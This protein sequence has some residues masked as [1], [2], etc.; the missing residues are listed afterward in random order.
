MSAIKSERRHAA[1]LQLHAPTLVEV[2]GQRD[3]SMHPNLAAVYE[4]VSPNSDAYGKK[5][6]GVLRDLSTN[7]AFLS[8]EAL[9]LMSRLAFTFKLE[10]FGQIEVLGWV[11][12]RRSTACEIPREGQPAL[13]LAAGFGVL[14]EA[15]PLDARL[16]IARLVGELADPAK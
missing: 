7:G 2:I 4:R 10:D 12:W 13:F 3:L 5:F 15:I 8:G 9:P 6:P 16:A 14:F 11:M 1:R